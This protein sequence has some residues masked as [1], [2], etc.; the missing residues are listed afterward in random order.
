MLYLYGFTC[1]TCQRGS[2]IAINNGNLH[3][4]LT[5]TLSF[6][7]FTTT[8]PSSPIIAS[9]PRNEKVAGECATATADAVLIAATAAAAQTDTSGHCIVLA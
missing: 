3:V 1:I 4:K 6:C 2:K 5:R 9:V 8:I 7:A